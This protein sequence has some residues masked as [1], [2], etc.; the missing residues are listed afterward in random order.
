MPPEL[1]RKRMKKDL[2]MAVGKV[3]PKCNSLWC[4]EVTKWVL[5]CDGVCDTPQCNFTLSRKPRATT[6]IQN[7]ANNWSSNFFQHKEI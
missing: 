1:T 4:I 7:E 2:R 6:D 5:S 3:H